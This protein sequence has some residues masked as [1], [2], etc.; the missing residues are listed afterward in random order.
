MP[1]LTRPTLQWIGGI[2][3]ALLLASFAVRGYSA[4]A[5]HILDG[6]SA[7]FVFGVGTALLIQGQRLQ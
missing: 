1:P 3:I 5:G 6:L 4:M 2:G 7:A